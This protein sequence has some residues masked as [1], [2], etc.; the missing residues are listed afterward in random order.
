METEAW[1]LAEHTHF[2]RLHPQL[3]PDLIAR[4]LG[5]DPR[6]DDMQLREVPSKDL[7]DAYFLVQLVYDKSQARV[8]RT[9]D[10]LDLELICST[11]CTKS[12]DLGRLVKGVEDFFAPGDGRSQSRD[13]V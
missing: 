2:A 4:E 12:E 8:E 5:F 13:D 6:N 1:L 9:L 11:P 10:H 3:S 7:Q